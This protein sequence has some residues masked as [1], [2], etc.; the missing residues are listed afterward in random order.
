MVLANAAKRFCDPCEGSET[1]LR[2]HDVIR[3]WSY[4]I[5]LLILLVPEVL[6][7]GY[8]LYRLI[9]KGEKPL[10]MEALCWVSIYFK[11]CE[12]IN[13]PLGNF[14]TWNRKKL[15]VVSVK[16]ADPLNTVVSFGQFN[17]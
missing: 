10:S 1:D 7:M 6:T 12:V 11:E 17:S 16:G 5:L 3:V 14:V 8:S 4:L 15:M 13:N 2:L 9:M